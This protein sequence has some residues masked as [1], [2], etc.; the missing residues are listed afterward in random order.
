MNKQEEFEIEQIAKI[1]R[2]SCCNIRPLYNCT[3]DCESCIAEDLHNAG[4][5]VVDKGKLYQVPCGIGDTIY[6]VYSA[7]GIE[8]WE[9]TAIRICK[10]KTIFYLSHH[11]TDDTDDYNAVL[12][13]ELD[14]YWFI[15]SEKAKQK[16]EKLQQQL[17]AALKEVH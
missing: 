15:D 1:I 13:T 16:L 3:A 5:R 6:I 4:C 17:A 8:E 7:S 2:N 9:I 14:D 10:E 11:D 12:L